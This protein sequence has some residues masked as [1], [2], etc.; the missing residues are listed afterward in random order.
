MRRP[1]QYSQRTEL[2]FNITP[3]IDVVFLLII[4]FLV[5]SHFVRSEQA[6]PVDLPLAGSGQMDHDQAPY[7]LTVTIAKDGS[8]FISGESESEAAVFRRIEEL[9]QTA[10]AAG[11][12]PEVRIRPDKLGQHGPFRR[13]Y[14]HCARHNI[15][16]IQFAVTTE[17]GA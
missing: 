7:R 5:A 10:A 9:Q 6:Q 1:S 15:R 4:F 14:E 2:R 3:L 16:R 12:D 13:L 17:G 8:L 11:M